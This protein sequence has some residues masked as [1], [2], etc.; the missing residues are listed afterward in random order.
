VA[1]L[2]LL[3]GLLLSAL[4]VGLFAVSESKSPT[5][6]IPAVFGIALIMLGLAASDFKEKA[7]M[8]AMHAAALV[9]LIGLAIPSYMVVKTLTEAGDWTRATTGQMAMAALCGLFLALCVKS[10]FDA[11]RRR[12][13]QGSA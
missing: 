9:G 8:H 5:A 7:R 3:F 1:P 2:T 6:L 10:F 4:G 13:Q 11:R 12:K